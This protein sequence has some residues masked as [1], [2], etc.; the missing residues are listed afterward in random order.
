MQKP[1]E[2]L[3]RSVEKDPIQLIHVNL[4]TGKTKLTSQ[5]NSKGLQ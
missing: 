1:K 3:N 5:W 4:N 2:D